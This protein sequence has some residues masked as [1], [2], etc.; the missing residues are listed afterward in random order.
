MLCFAFLLILPLCC[1]I[2]INGN[3]IACAASCEAVVDSG[4]SLIIGS[5]NDI[6]NINGWL[7]AVP[8]QYDNVSVLNVLLLASIIFIVFSELFLKKK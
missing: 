1:S 7:G 3:I 8:S 6:S 5:S 4:T 2:T